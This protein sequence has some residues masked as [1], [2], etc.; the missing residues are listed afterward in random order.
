V[1][2]RQNEQGLRIRAFP[3]LPGSDFD[4]VL[5]EAKAY[6]KDHP[7]LEEELVGKVTHPI[8]R[9]DRDLVEEINKNTAAKVAKAHRKRLMQFFV[10]KN[11]PPDLAGEI[12][13]DLILSADT[14]PSFFQ[15]LGETIRCLTS[16]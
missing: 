2:Y 6:H 11:V 1:P 5:D 8:H 16:W 3:Q 14:P 12:V 10:Q 15:K 9:Q 4:D 7:P 13:D